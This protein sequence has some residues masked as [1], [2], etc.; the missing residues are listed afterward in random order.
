MK[1][2]QLVKL[3]Q[4]KDQNKEVEFIV[5][6]KDDGSIVC[7]AMENQATAV[8]KALKLFRP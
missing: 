1:I 2:K 4:T 8:V 3:L 7:M 6:G 5:A